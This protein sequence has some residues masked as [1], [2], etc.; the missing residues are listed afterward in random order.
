MT[1]FTYKF[2]R[3]KIGG[4]KVWLGTL[5]REIEAEVTKGS[6]NI[7]LDGLVADDTITDQYDE[8]YLHV[9]M[10]SVLPGDERI[11]LESVV[12]AHTGVPTPDNNV[13]PRTGMEVVSVSPYAWSPETY[14]RTGYL[15][16]VPADSTYF[17][18]VQVT[19]ELY[20][21]GGS[22]LYEN[23][24]RGDYVE[25]SVVDKD[26]A[27]GLFALYG[28]EVG[29]H[30]LEVGKLLRSLYL[31]P[32]KNEKQLTPPTASQV[33]QGLYLRVGVTSVGDEPLRC[34]IEI[35]AYEE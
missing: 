13:D 25:F 26:D 3:N 2:S 35:E 33:F 11:V 16:E 30:V 5:E 15:V 4:G 28:M 6:I 1:T 23:A 31:Q 32:G 22:I 18:D 9:V 20:V 12:A 27:L 10:R 19:K 17:L 29:T 24:V 7:P 34:S 21:K 8:E 14:Q